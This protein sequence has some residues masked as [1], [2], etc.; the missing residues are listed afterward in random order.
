MTSTSATAT[1][2]INDSGCYYGLADSQRDDLRTGVTQVAAPESAVA[3]GRLHQ[4]SRALVTG[5]SEEDLRRRFSGL[6]TAHH[7][8]W[9]R[10]RRSRATPASRLP[11]KLAWR[12][13][14]LQIRRYE[15]TRGRQDVPPAAD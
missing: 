4:R 14:R 8:D 1:T 2:L 15:L 10:W 13:G 3:D 7:R 6:G 11:L 9:S 5:I 12:S